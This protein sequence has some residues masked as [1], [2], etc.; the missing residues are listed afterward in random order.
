MKKLALVAAIVLAG[1][2]A[3][4]QRPARVGTCALTRISN[5]T[6]RL[7]DGVTRRVIPD[8]GSAVSFANG[9]YQVSYDQVA[10]VNRSQRGDP[11]YICLM[12][13]PENCPPGDDR[14]RLYTTTNLRS[15]E[16]WT[17]PDAEHGCGGA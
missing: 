11:V 10:A 14:G 3:Q 5:V 6:Q 8:S 13:L 9:L 17:L 15:E 16:S 12:K 1:Q 7:E 2:P 4:A